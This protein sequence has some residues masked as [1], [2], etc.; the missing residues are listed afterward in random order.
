[1]CSTCGAAK[2]KR[3]DTA[4]HDAPGRRITVSTTMAKASKGYLR[5]HP[6]CVKCYA[7]GALVPSTVTDHIVPH[8]GNQKLAWDTGNW[9][10][11]CKPCHD[12][13]TAG[14]RNAIRRGI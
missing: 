12:V 8:R 4:R 3:E 1:M 13:K 6:L 10:A 7:D 11:L 9:Q 14:E 5:H 2:R